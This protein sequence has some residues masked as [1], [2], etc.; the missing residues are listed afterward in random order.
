LRTCACVSSGVNH[1]TQNSPHDVESID[2]YLVRAEQSRVVMEGKKKKMKEEEP[3]RV[4]SK[5]ILLV[6]DCE[7]ICAS[8]GDLRRALGI[9]NNSPLKVLSIFGNTGDGKSHTLNHTFFEGQEVFNTSDSQQP[10]TV[11]MW[12]SYDDMTNTLLIDTE[13]LLGVSANS[14]RRTRLLL[15]ILALSDVVVYR[16]RAE[17]LHNDMF[18]FLKDASKAYCEHFTKDLQQ[19]AERNNIDVPLSTLGPSVLI[20]HE[21]QF[22]EPLDSV[23]NTPLTDDEKGSNVTRSADSQISQRFIALGALPQAF[24]TIRYCGTRTTEAPTDFTKFRQAVIS[25]LQTNSIRN[26]KSLS[27]VLESLQILNTKFSG[28]IIPEQAATFSDAY[29]RCNAVCQSCGG[30]CNKSVSHEDEVHTTGTKYCRYQHQYKNRVYICFKCYDGGKRN[31]VVPKSYED[32]ESPWSGFAKMAW[33]GYVIECPEC[34]VIYRSRQYWYGNKDPEQESVRTEVVHI[35]PGEEGKLDFPGRYMLDQ[36]CSLSETVGKYSAGPTQM[37]T[38]WLND[39]VCPPYWVPNHLITKC[40][41][42]KVEFVPMAQ[43]HH[44]RA[45]GQGF[46][47]EC[48][49]KTKPVEWRGWGDYP[50]RVCNRCFDASDKELTEEFLHSLTAWKVTECI[51]SAAS[52]VKAVADVPKSVLT[53]VVRPDYWVPDA[54]IVQCSA[55]KEPLIEKHHC[56]SCGQG[57]CS[58]CS[59]GR[60][61]CP[62]RGWDYPVRVCDECSKLL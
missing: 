44:C 28:R 35:W 5:S 19:V 29:F 49:E 21:T 13:G 33:S 32:S 23:V 41:A 40:F 56:R 62:D 50:V 51:K 31:E 52:V 4:Y 27:V 46:C 48:S 9:E 59:S 53:D 38:D 14:N 1:T 12:I 36:L 34:G 30:Q 18:V 60:K 54:D 26:G 24:S 20:F 16:T 43:K 61:A 42:C 37:V 39:Q 25:E 55:C 2:E 8:T 7:K 22:V 47:H 58:D 17:R 57:F 6:D 15:K 3:K 10:G 45:C 11:G